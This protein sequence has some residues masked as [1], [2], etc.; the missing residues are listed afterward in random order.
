LGVDA[1]HRRLVSPAQ[2]GQAISFPVL[3]L[4]LGRILDI[5]CLLSGRIDGQSVENPEN[6]AKEYRL[7]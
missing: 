1:E 2:C 4:I 3:W 6:R 7:R 5:A